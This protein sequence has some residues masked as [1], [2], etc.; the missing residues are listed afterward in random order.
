MASITSNDDELL[1]ALLAQRQPRK[2]GCVSSAIEV[3]CTVA[4]VALAVCG[5]YFLLEIWLGAPAAPQV[6]DVRDR[7]QPP[8]VLPMGNIPRQQQPVYVPA[9]LPDCATVHDTTT[10]CQRDD[11]YNVNVT[12]TPT[13]APTP[14]AEGF[15]SA[16][17]LA[18]FT[19]TAEAFYNPDLIPTAPP[20]F[21]QAVQEGCADPTK[22]A[23][24]PLLASWCG[25][26]E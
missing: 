21:V 13:A 19:A 9:P 25:P 3:A 1:A 8:T 6:Q 23:Q 26:D 17:D 22:I 16:E 14:T 15:W 12:P 24:S 11:V 7:V 18:A 5:G 4:V 10:A 20:A 2:K